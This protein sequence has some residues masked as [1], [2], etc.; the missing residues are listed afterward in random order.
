MARSLWSAPMLGYRLGPDDGT[1]SVR[2]RRTGA[3]AMAG[4]NLLMHATSW[5]A[6][7]ELGDHMAVE[8][9]VDGS[10]LRVREGSGGMQEL[11]DEDKENIRQTIDAEVL[12]RETIK[13]RSG[14]VA[15]AGAGL[16]VTGD[17]TLNG[18]T[19]PLAF[20]LA[21]TADGRIEGTAVVKQS[22]WGMKPYTGL[23]GALKVVDE[24]EVGIDA[25][26][27]EPQSA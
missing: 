26:L 14:E 9:D 8:L 19:R 4:H 25:R 15:P 18:Q 24:V 1:L 7:I 2:T 13:F 3:A 10:S 16:H 21:L 22:D 12:N 5:E 20:E 11:Q 27:P 6:T 23:F 17:L